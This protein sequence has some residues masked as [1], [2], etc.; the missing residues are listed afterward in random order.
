MHLESLKMFCDVV[1]TGTFSAA[2]RRSQV[3]QSAV[4]QCVSSLEDRYAVQLL[5][6]GARRVRPTPAGERLARAVADIL[7]RM[8]ELESDLRERVPGSRTTTVSTSYAM[9]L[10]ELRDVQRALE[11][12]VTLVLLHRRPEEVYDDVIVGAADLGLVAYPAARGPAEVIPLRDD[13]LVAIMPP[14]HAL[15]AEREVSP[16]ALARLPFVAFD[17]QLP[18]GAGIARLFHDQGLELRPSLQVHNVETLKRAVELGHGVSV[19]PRPTVAHEL[20]AGT[21]VAR[22]IAGRR[23][24]RPVGLVV[25]KDRYRTRAAQAALD[26]FLRSAHHAVPPHRRSTE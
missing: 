2:A 22:P 11:P 12:A 17:A 26:A 1:Q 4:S 5:A 20:A 23:W 8:R 3:T 13:P 6:R 10:H 19:L 9:G 15:A 25:C 24:T 18:T 7:T 14:G 21:L 16:A